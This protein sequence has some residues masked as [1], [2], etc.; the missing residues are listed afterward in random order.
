LIAHEI[1]A[2]RTVTQI[3][4]LGQALGTVCLVPVFPRSA[5]CDAIYTHAPDRDCLL[6]VWVSLRRIDLQQTATIE[7]AREHLERRGWRAEEPRTDVELHL[8]PGVGSE[9]TP[10]METETVG[11]FRRILESD[12]RGQENEP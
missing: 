12:D 1:A 4:P 5:I 2:L 9:V 7:D 6:T 11:F 8:Y 10:Q 3:V